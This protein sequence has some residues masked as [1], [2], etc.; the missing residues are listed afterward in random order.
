MDSVLKSVFDNDSVDRFPFSPTSGKNTIFKLF[1]L[2]EGLKSDNDDYLSTIVNQQSS[3]I[4]TKH[5]MLQEFVIKN[6]IRIID[7]D[8]TCYKN[9]YQGHSLLDKVISNWRFLYMTESEPFVHCMC[10][11][12]IRINYCF[13]NALTREI[14]YIGMDCLAM[15]YG[16]EMHTVPSALENLLL[17]PNDPCGKALIE[18]CLCYQ[19]ISTEDSTVLNYQHLY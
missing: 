6:K 12:P 18:Y 14:I 4:T 10:G 3:H 13:Q 5:Q 1:S 17:K 8:K 16:S 9:H 7:I 19:L 15:F 11:E 2:D